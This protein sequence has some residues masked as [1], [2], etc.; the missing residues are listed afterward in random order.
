MGIVHCF[1]PTHHTLFF[2]LPALKTGLICGQQTTGCN[3]NKTFLEE[4]VQSTL[5][6]ISQDFTKRGLN[7]YTYIHIYKT[8]ACIKH[9]CTQDLSSSPTGLY[10][11]IY[12]TQMNWN[13]WKK[14]INEHRWNSKNCLE[15]DL[16]PRPR[17]YIYIYTFNF[18]FIRPLT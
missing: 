1:P 4:F 18:S 16:S 3:S 10:I 5:Y 8:Q 15:R 11:Y 12:I 14:E 7:I 13:Q 9:P 2:T 17:L 6:L